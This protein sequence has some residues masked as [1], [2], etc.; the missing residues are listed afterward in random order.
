MPS[1][2]SIYFGRWMER[3]LPDA[4]VE[5]KRGPDGPRGL[6]SIVLSGDAD[7]SITRPDPNT[8]E[9]HAGG[10]VRRSLGDGI[11][12]RD[13]DVDPAP[14][15]GRV[16]LPWT[17]SL[18]CKRRTASYASLDDESWLCSIELTRR[19]SMTEPNSKQ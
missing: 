4:R 12:P 17:S 8:L 6:R 10:R 13:E 1:P 2:S 11:P 14:A 5:L 18:F 15:E 3:A 7:V 9:V 16:K 19:S